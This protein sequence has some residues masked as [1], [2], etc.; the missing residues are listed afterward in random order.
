MPSSFWFGGCRKMTG[1]LNLKGIVLAGLM[2]AQSL[3]RLIDD[4]AGIDP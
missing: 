3:I 2:Q 1:I 4:P